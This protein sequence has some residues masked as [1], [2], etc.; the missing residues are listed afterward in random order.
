MV[1]RQPQVG[2][3]QPLS[4]AGLATPPFF[5][6]QTTRGH[7]FVGRL[8]TPVGGDTFE[9]VACQMPPPYPLSKV[10]HLQV[11]TV[12][13]YAKLSWIACTEK[14]KFIFVFGKTKMVPMADN[15]NSG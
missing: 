8:P 15:L 7:R 2:N 10:R 13:R 6:H 4:V 12:V 14:Y 3:T 11:A 5:H 1:G 9:M